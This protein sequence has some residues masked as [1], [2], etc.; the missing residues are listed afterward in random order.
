MKKFMIFSM[1]CLMALTAKA[2]VLTSATVNKVYQSA[3]KESGDE[4]A[5]ETERDD[6]DNITTMYVYQKENR[7][8]G[9]DNL[10]PV[11]RYQYV[12]TADG[13]LSSR[14]KSLWRKGDWQL[15]GR[16]DYTLTD[17]SYTVEFSRW[18]KKKAVYDLP[19]GRMTYT[20]MPDH[21]VANIAC[22]FRQY[23]DT[24]LELAW[25]APV[26]SLPISMDYY[27]THAR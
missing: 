21:S 23:N 14:T 5:Y 19:L 18:N 1:M 12:Y 6:N 8:K 20:L 10:K 2:Q 4:F 11:C 25:Q 9:K 27:L 15:F 26:E 13:L 22:Y 7:H 24:P 17:D 3:I 16:H